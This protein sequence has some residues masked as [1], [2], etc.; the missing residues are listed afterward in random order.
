[1]LRTLDNLETQL[2]GLIDTK[3]RLQGSLNTLR[4]P[5]ETLEKLA[6]TLGKVIPGLKG[7]VLIIRNLPLP[8]AFPPGVGLPA[9]VLNNFSNALDVLKVVIDKLDGPISV[10]S[11]GVE[12]IV[13]VILPILG[14]LKLLDPIFTQAQQIIIFIR[15]L[16]L[17]GPFAS[18][19][20]INQVASDVN[21]RSTAILE[22]APGPFSSSSNGKWVF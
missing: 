16:L 10:V 5:I 8:T 15:A 9:T 3:N 13:K 1:M 19:Q 14:K 12:Q 18:Q 17:Y 6:D 21:G 7:V 22:S 2:N 11:L 20:D 4:K